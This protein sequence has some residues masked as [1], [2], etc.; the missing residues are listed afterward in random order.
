MPNNH[1]LHHRIPPSGAPSRCLSFCK[2]PGEIW[3]LH[4]NL[5]ASRHPST[6]ASKTSASGIERPM[7]PAYIS[8]ALVHL[9]LPSR[10][11]TATYLDSVV[12]DPNVKAAYAKDRWA[13]NFFK[14]G[15][16]SLEKVV[17]SIC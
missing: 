9:L 7:T 5:E 1:S 10:P 2:R 17:S 14:D 8:F 13:T 12:L 4:P 3:P 16:K 11:P 15:M 6:Q